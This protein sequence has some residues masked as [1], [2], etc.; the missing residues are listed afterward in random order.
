ADRAPSSEPRRSRSYRALG[1]V[2]AALVAPVVAEF[3]VVQ[4]VQLVCVV[5]EAIG[6]PAHLVEVL[7]VIPGRCPLLA[8]LPDDVQLLVAELGHPRQDFLKIH[9]APPARYRPGRA[10]DDRG[11]RQKVLVGDMLSP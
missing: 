8:P 2:G 11:F 3:V 9:Q 5:V 6:D 10:Y 7:A 4:A 1:A